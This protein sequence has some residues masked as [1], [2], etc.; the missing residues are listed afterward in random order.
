MKKVIS[1]ATMTMMQMC[2][3]TFRMCMTCAEPFSDVSSAKV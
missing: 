2:M 3:W 1:S